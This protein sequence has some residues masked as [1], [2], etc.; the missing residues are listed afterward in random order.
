M[1]PL[2]GGQFRPMPFYVG[3]LLFYL[4]SLTV[5]ETGREEVG[6]ERGGGKR[7]VPIS[8]SNTHYYET[9]LP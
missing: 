7:G 9:G 6:W 1:I 5:F 3:L 8:L 2:L 4:V